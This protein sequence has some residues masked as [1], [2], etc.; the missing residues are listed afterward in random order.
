MEDYYEVWGIPAVVVA[1]FK[2]E[3]YVEVWHLT[4]NGSGFEVFAQGEETGPDGE[5]ATPKQEWTWHAPV[6]RH[7]PVGSKMLASASLVAPNTIQII[8]LAEDHGITEIQTH[9]FAATGVEVEPSGY[10]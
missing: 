2:E 8:Y 3:P 6:K 5:D 4:K 9:K 10:Q 7:S 1:R